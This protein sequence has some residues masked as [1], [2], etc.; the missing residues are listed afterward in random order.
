[1]VALLKTKDK[2]FSKKWFITYGLIVAGTFLVA[3]GYVLFV[4][5]YKIVPG[6]IYGISIVLHYLIGV[7]VG[8]MALA[9]NIPLTILAL[10]L[11]GPRFGVK[12]VVTFVLTSVFVDVLSMFSNYK[13]L[14]ENDALLSSI[15]GGAVIGLGVGIIF[16]AKAT[17][18][19]S[20]VIAMILSKYTKLPVGQM[21]IAVDSCIVLFGL[22]AFRDWKIPFYSWIVIFI[23]GKVIDVV[24]EGI[25]YDKTL[26][27][28]SDKHE[29]IREKILFD[30]KR[31]GTYLTGKGMYNGNDKSIIFTVVNRRELAILEEYINEI[32]PNAFLSVIN[33]N[34]IL[35][36]GFKSLNEKLSE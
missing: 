26:F 8:M 15:F 25:S 10:K 9:F 19:G 24:M 6:G 5:P 13:P 34:E 18:A 27:I 21:M 20:D 12:T 3:C 33:A 11:L 35:G 31:G 16:K 7:P 36:K 32:D 28:I 14:V 4:T 2:P 1:M 23:M 22:I 17:S 29:E 30:L